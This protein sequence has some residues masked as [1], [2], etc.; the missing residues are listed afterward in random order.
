MVTVISLR[1]A[2]WALLR[3]LGVSAC[4]AGLAAPLAAPVRADM[5]GNAFLMALTNAGVSYPHPA[6]A[7]ALGQSVCPMLVEPGQSFD[8]VAAEMEQRSG[9]GYESAGLFTIVAVA[10]FCPAVIAPLLQNRLTAY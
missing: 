8:S 7:L 10:N 3:V 6:G 1:R 9:L 2:E 4:V 5:R